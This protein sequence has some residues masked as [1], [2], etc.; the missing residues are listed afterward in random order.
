MISFKTIIYF[1]LKIRGRGNGILSKIY[2]KFAN[3]N[4]ADPIPI[5]DLHSNDHKKILVEIEVVQK[6]K[7]NVFVNVFYISLNLSNNFYYITP[8]PKITETI[9]CT[10]TVTVPQNSVLIVNHATSC[11]YGYNLDLLSLCEW[12]MITRPVWG[13]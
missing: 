6:K 8:A 9:T 2:G 11:Y 13:L 4:L 5:G 10:A 12:I 3:H 7:I 1:I